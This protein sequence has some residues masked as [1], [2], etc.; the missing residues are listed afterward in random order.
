MK[1]IIFFAVAIFL[2]SLVSASDAVFIA[3]NSVYSFSDYI[4]PQEKAKSVGEL[5]QMMNYNQEKINI[6]I[7]QIS[8]NKKIAYEN[9]KEIPQAV[10]CFLSMESLL[11]AVGILVSDV[12]R[13]LNNSFQITTSAEENILSRSKIAYFLVGGDFNSANEIESEINSNKE[14]ISVLRELNLRSNG[15]QEVKN[16][17]EEQIKN[18]EDEQAR[19]QEI[20]N[21]EKSTKGLIGWVWK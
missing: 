7:N 19:L 3:T 9:Q 15:S 12:A 2:L 8:E 21:S 1:K 16:I 18:I 11:P 4:S 14:R 20:V 13:Q 5:E 6:A 10:Y 17:F